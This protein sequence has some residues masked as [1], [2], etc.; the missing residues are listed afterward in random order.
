MVTKLKLYVWIAATM[1]SLL[2]A[3]AIYAAAPTWQIDAKD[4]SINFTATQNGAPVT[5]QFKNFSGTINFDPNQLSTSQVQIKVDMA[6]VSAAYAQIATTLKTADFFDVQK[7]TQAIFKASDF[8][9]TGSNTYQAKGT[10]TLRDKTLPVV[11]NFTMDT[12]TANKAVATGSASLSRTQFGVGQGS[13]AST[14]QIKDPVQ[15]NFN[16]TATR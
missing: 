3:T 7:Y 8:T 9:K 12:Y 14:D 6:S 13:W 4:S 1:G 11:L 2:L 5:G 15:V 16:L 10:L